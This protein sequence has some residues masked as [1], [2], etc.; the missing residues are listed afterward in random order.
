MGAAIKD[1]ELNRQATFPTTSPDHHR[2][3]L[4]LYSSH[5]LNITLAEPLSSAELSENGERESGAE[6]FGGIRSI[7]V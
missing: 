5:I 7:C 1:A 6:G 2:S 3:G 4:S